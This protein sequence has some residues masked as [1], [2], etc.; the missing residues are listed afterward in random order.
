VLMTP[1]SFDN[2]HGISVL[3]AFAASWSR[4]GGRRLCSKQT[5]C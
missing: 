4:E 3:R 5:S 2:S 1:C